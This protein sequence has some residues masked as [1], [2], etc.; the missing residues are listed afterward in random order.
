MDGK[1]IGKG[2]CK[3]FNKEKKLIYEGEVLNWINNGKG[4]EYND[5]GILIYEGEYLNGKKSGKGKRRI[6]E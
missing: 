6:F 5:N 3:K 2:K 4:K 1:P